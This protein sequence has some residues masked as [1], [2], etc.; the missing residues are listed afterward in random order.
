MTMI[1]FNCNFAEAFGLLV[2]HLVPVGVCLINFEGRKPLQVFQKRIAQG[3][4]LTP[5]FSQEFFGKALYCHNRNGNQW[6]TKK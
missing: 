4:V 5:V 1:E 2:H 6:N 3:G